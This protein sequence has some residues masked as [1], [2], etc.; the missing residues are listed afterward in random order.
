MTVIR[1]T[2]YHNKML[3]SGDNKLF[4]STRRLFP[5]VIGARPLIFIYSLKDRS[6]AIY[7]LGCGM[8]TANA[9]SWWEV[10]PETLWALLLSS[11]TLTSS[12]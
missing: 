9:P 1:T 10:H 12:W 6:Q 5:Y 11:L 2:T 8:E 4:K 7:W 3:P